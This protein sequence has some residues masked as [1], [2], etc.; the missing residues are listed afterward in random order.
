[1]I[2]KQF[3]GMLKKWILKHVASLN[4]VML[5]DREQK[6]LSIKNNTLFCGMLDLNYLCIAKL[7]DYVI[8][9]MYYKFICIS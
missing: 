1:M 5:C 2:H 6:K 8:W 9:T 4:K 7:F 3:L